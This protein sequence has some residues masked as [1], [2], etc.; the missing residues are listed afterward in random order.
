MSLIKEGDFGGQTTGETLEDCHEKRG[1]DDAEQ[2]QIPHVGSEKDCHETHHNNESADNESDDDEIEFLT[3]K[4]RWQNLLSAILP[5]KESSSW[6][7]NDSFPPS[8]QQW[9][10]K[11]TNNSCSCCLCLDWFKLVSKVAA[12][13]LLQKNL[14]PT[15]PPVAKN[16][17]T[18]NVATSHWEKTQDE[19]KLAF[20]D[21][22]QD[23][24]A[25]RIRNSE[26]V[27]YMELKAQILALNVE[28]AAQHVE[29]NVK[30]IMSGHHLALQLIVSTVNFGIP[31]IHTKS[32]K[33]RMKKKRKREKR[34]RLSA[35]NKVR[36]IA[37]KITDND[38]SVK[39]LKIGFKTLPMDALSFH[40]FLTKLFVHTIASTNDR[41]VGCVESRSSCAQQAR[42]YHRLGSQMRDAPLNAILCKLS[43]IIKMHETVSCE[44]HVVD[45][46]GTPDRQPDTMATNF[47]AERHANEITPVHFVPIEV[48]G[49]TPDFQLTEGTA[50]LLEHLAGKAHSVVQSG[51]IGIRQ[52]YRGF[53]ISLIS[54]QILELEVTDDGTPEVSLQQRRT[55]RY[56]LFDYETTRRMLQGK[57]L[58]PGL[59]S[60][61]ADD[62]GTPRGFHLLVDFLQ[63]GSWAEIRRETQNLYASF[64]EHTAG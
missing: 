64:T 30:E 46:Q 6:N 44:Q 29:I 51:R 54:I 59:V 24:C 31:L 45:Q 13:Q 27:E 2:D 8:N 33:G 49:S 53:V 21:M 56:S 55:P 12:A 9:L 11:T 3:L 36:G 17:I 37:T 23:D 1:G 18:H 25:T 20:T 62:K 42:R 39:Q 57:E 28:V 63:S 58:A 52:K 16:I 34:M 22:T 38:E 40:L 48:A 50:E 35:T 19:F 10:I 5:Y 41:P 7:P 60:F 32:E 14:N 43:I 61:D 26:M 15:L 4:Q 47:A